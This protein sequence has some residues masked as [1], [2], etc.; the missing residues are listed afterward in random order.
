[1]QQSKKPYP[2]IQQGFGLVLLLMV[3]SLTGIFINGWFDIRENTPFV[4]AILAEMLGYS[5]CFTLGITYAL[6]KVNDSRGEKLKFTSV[7]ANILILAAVMTPFMGFLIE[8]LARI[9][10]VPES[11]DELFDDAFKNMSRPHILSFIAISVLPS[12]FEEIL[13]RGVILEGMLVRYRP[14]TAIFW[15]AFLFGIMHIHPVQSV[16]GFFL[17]IFIGWLYWKTRSLLPGMIV[18]FVN[19]AFSYILLISFGSWE[20][21]APEPVYILLLILS[22]VVVAFGIYRTS[23]LFRRN[24]VIAQPLNIGS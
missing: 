2:S 7:P 8:P 12:L 4:T 17:G 20:I 14:S 1:M 16:G 15:S 22:S 10:P 3:C 9:A 5:V 19:N 11:F 21:P 13:F 23:R 6:Y 24:E 18:H